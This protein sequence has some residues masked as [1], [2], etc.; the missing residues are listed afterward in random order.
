MF[1]ASQ[2]ELQDREW[3][4]ELRTHSGTVEFA[5]THL[6]KIKVSLNLAEAMA[7][8]RC[9]QWIQTTT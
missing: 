2:M 1:G 6:K 7:L 9:L 3:L 5:A 4:L 8:N